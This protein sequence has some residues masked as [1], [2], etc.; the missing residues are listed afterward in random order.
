MKESL[1][2]YIHYNMFHF[3]CKK[4]E[5]PQDRRMTLFICCIVNKISTEIFC[6]FTRSGGGWK[7]TR[8]LRIIA[9]M[10]NACLRCITHN[11]ET[12]SI[13][14]FALLCNSCFRSTHISSNMDHLCMSDI[15]LVSLN[16]KIKDDLRS[17]FWN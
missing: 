16:N 5:T 9:C 4:L 2:I 13:I 6:A 1:L 11:F 3:K 7:Y 12:R 8:K 17:I 15:L 14:F 10:E